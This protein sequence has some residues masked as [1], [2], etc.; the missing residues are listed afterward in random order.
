MNIKENSIVI[1]SDTE[2]V[3]FLKKIRKNKQLF[4]IKVMTLTEFKKKYFFDYTTKTT[5]YVHKKYNV[6]KDIAEIYIKNLYFIRDIDDEK[7]QFLLEVKKDLENQ[8]LLIRDDQFIK[9]L[10][11]KNIVLFNLGKLDNFYE[12]LFNDIKE[13]CTVET[14]ETNSTNSTSKELYKVPTR[15]I[16]VSFVAS[17]ICQL[18]KK[19]ININKIKIAGYSAEYYL[20]IYN[21][22]KIFNIPIELPNEDTVE[23]TIVFHK[24]KEFFSNDINNTVKEMEPL[25][26]TASDKDIYKKIVDVINK[27]TWAENLEDLQ[28]FIFADI[29]KIKLPTS[30]L[31]NAIQ[32]IDFPDYKPDDDEYII[33]INFTQGAIP[34]N[35]KDEDFLN[36]LTKNKLGCSNSIDINKKNIE[37]LQNAIKNTQNI[38]VTC[39]EQNLG[40]ELFI[41]NAYTQ[42][43]FTEQQYVIDFNSS[44]EFNKRTLLKYRDENRKYGTINENLLLL[45][46]QYQ[47]TPY[48]DYDNSFK[49]IDKN[50]LFDYLGNKLT[51]SYSSMNTYYMCEFRYY[52]DNIL[53]VN[54]FEDTFE[55]TI[56]NIFHKILSECFQNDF[57]F[58][59]AWSNTINTCE[60]QFNINENFFLTI[61]KPELIFIIETIKKQSEYTTLKNALFEQKIEV[62]IDE[63]KD[64][65]FKGFIDKI[66]FDEEKKV[67]AIIDYKT[68]NPNLSLDNCL[69]GLD[70]QLPIYAFLIK[71]Y[72][73]FKHSKLGGFYLQKILNNKNNMEE[74]VDALKLQGYSNADLTILEKVDNTYE[75]S[76]LIKSMKT[77]S[78]G[79]STYAKILNDDE[80]DKL[81]KLVY[82]KIKEA[83]NNILEAKFDINPKEINGKNEGCKFCKYKDIC[84]MKNKNIVK[85]K[86]TK[87]E[88]FLG[89]DNH[90]YMD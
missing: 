55:T 33:L 10:Q 63:T 88:D 20:L 25:L 78:N 85:L 17:Y 9:Y 47:E 13:I 65:L 79:L 26:H 52:L 21:T 90:A 66:L 15:E 48:L 34:K 68:G 51:L 29:R 8:N 50:K 30:H 72:E 86:K 32:I 67:A 62:K 35:K 84:Y 42:E 22:F 74:K 6:I 43:L 2:K 1:T 83:Y 58:E 81:T 3:S 31:K 70:M 89:G 41:S 24:F 28:E 60:Y 80:I 36:D 64:I 71:N 16:E 56:G 46:S 54:K 23:S 82:Q 59:E 57:N 77:T 61:L 45:N 75:Q 73:P 37:N 7:V 38:I 4:N 49:G 18:I 11:G 40:E 76:K 69:Y 87:K 44:H 5:Y 12:N 39:P 53:K 14:I 19:G 27:Y